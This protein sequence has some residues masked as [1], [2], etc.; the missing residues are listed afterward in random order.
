MMASRTKNDEIDLLRKQLRWVPSEKDGFA[1]GAIIGSPYPDGTIGI[2]LME[3]GERQ[4]ASSDQ[5]QKPNPPKCEDMAMLTCLNEP[6]VLHNLKQRY[7]SNLY[8]TYSGLF[9]VVI[10]PYKRIPI[11]T[12]TIAEQFN[13]KKSEEMPPHIFA[14]AHEAYRS[15]LPTRG[16][17]KHS[18]AIG[19]IESLFF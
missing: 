12:D 2:E 9:C 13:C 5:C 15:M 14:V 11:Y 18:Q 16:N 4:C 3:T 6:S 19:R 10:N 8:H 17:C 1:L 7:F